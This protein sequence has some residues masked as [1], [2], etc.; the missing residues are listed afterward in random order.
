MNVRISRVPLVTEKEEDAL[1]QLHSRYF[2][3]VKR[4]VFHEDF[5][6]KSWVITARDGAGGY[7]AF[8]T[9]R[10]YA[11]RIG[12]DEVSVIFSGDTVVRPD[13]WKRNLIAPAFAAFLKRSMDEAGEKPLYW[14]LLSKGYRTFMFMPAFF[15]SFHPSPDTGGESL[16]PVLDELASRRYGKD[17]DPRTGVMSRNGEA[18]A[19]RDELAEVPES[20][21]EG[22][23]VRF[24][25][26][27]N[28]L[29]RRGDELCC[30]TRVERANIKPLG[31]R[32][33]EFKEFEWAE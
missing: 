9:I 17:Y 16:K 1:Y 15:I 22:R 18:D 19:L 5:R 14:F 3:S 8:S 21:R 4:A 26:E 23:H 11:D 28:P 6:E 20:R 30:L 12:G 13:S 27:A 7:A 33:L 32:I 2:S 29:Y 31:L 10:T 25:L 24:F